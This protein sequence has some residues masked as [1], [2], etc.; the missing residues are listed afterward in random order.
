MATPPLSEQE[1]QALT[2]PQTAALYRKRAAD[3]S[4]RIAE[5][6]AAEP[7]LAAFEQLAQ[8]RRQQSEGALLNALAAQFA[9]E[10]FQPVQAQFLRQAA[11]SQEPMKL[12]GGMVTPDGK[13]LRDPFAARER[14]I[15]N[16]M[17]QAKSYE[18]MALTAQTVQEREDARRAQ[19]EIAN[20]LRLM[21]LQMRQQGKG[22]EPRFQ[23]SG[24]FALPTG[25]VVPGMF[26]PGQGY[27]YQGPNGLAPL[28][29]GS[30]PVPPST[31]GPVTPMQFNKLVDD[32]EDERSAVNKLNRYFAT[33]KDTNVGFARMADQIAANAKTLFAQPLNQKELSRQVAQGQLQGLLGLFRTDIVGP[34]VMTEYD[35]QRVLQALGGDLNALQNPQTVQAL[36]KDMY[37]SKRRR[38]G[39]LERQVDYSSRYFPGVAPQSQPLPGF[40]AQPNAAP[41]AA[42]ASNFGAPPPGAVRRKD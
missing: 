18:Q 27:V 6:D 40:G 16:L 2:L 21:G 20:Q 28:P 1:L 15:N 12:S 26:N 9:G 32:L 39:V 3:I 31:G 23:Q 10:R 30:R 34:G 24:P 41:G 5:L 29:P 7:D 25:E 42:P 14:Q 22:N 36:L 17:N 4:G 8:S 13:F 38:I 19:N 33:V 37:E 11:A 35:A